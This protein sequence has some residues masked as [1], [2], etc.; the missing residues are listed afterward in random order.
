MAGMKTEGEELKK[1]LKLGRKRPL[2]F[3]FCIG[4]S[5]EDHLLII[6]RKRKPAMLGK[7]ARA[8]GLGSKIAF[9]MLAVSGRL[10]TLTCEREAPA[11]AKKMKRFLIRQK[12]KL[13]VLVLDAAGRE[14]ESDIEDLEEDPGWNRDDQDAGDDLQTPKV[15]AGDTPAGPAVGDGHRATLVSRLKAIQPGVMA[16]KGEQGEKL[17]RVLTLAAAHLKAGDLAKAAQSIAALEKALAPSGSR[18]PAPENKAKPAATTP[19]TPAVGPAEL[20]PRLDAARKAIAE[21]D[22]TIAAK[23]NKAVFIVSRLIAAQ[24]Y[25]KAHATLQKITQALSRHSPEARNDTHPE[26][27]A[28]SRAAWLR[29]RQTLSRGLQKLKEA[30]DAGTSDVPALEGVSARSAIPFDHARALDARLEKT[31]EKLTRASDDTE[32]EQLRAQALGLVEEY[33]AELDR[34]FFTAVDD[35]GFANTDLRAMALAALKQV[36]AALG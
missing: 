27:V 7:A 26:P 17:K 23:L 19:A 25:A 12:L 11:L 3:G 4:P 32:R 24:D 36:R 15:A 21:L 6:H 35:N 2:P 13:N 8:E 33:R 10:V 1:L 34:P 9:G 31:L 14:L 20:V 29:S 30:I 18:D 5:D 16:A 28:A 22:D